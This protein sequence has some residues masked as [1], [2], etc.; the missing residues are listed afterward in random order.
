MPLASIRPGGMLDGMLRRFFLLLLLVAAP[1]LA[2]ADDPDLPPLDPP[3]QWR[4]LTHDDE[5]STS[6]CIGDPKTPLCALETTRAC[7]WRALSRLCR[8]VEV[9]RMPSRPR[10]ATS[11]LSYRIVSARRLSVEAPPD[12]EKEWPYDW[13][14]GDVL[15]GTFQRDCYGKLPVERQCDI[16]AEE[17]PPIY[18]RA[19]R[20]GSRWISP[21][22][23]QERF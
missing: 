18:Y 13:R 7:S 3:G 10:P 16:G 2:Q 9:D 6:K 4:V 1:A 5:T 22:R 20:K 15:I 17:R 21:Y 14:P 11:W 19:E 12:R 8:M 23:Y